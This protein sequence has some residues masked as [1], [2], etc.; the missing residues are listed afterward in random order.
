MRKASACRL[1]HL[2]V[3]L[4]ILMGQDILSPHRRLPPHA[5]LLIV[6]AR[7]VAQRAACCCAP[8]PLDAATLGAGLEAE[9][10]TP[11]AFYNVVAVSQRPSPGRISRVAKAMARSSGGIFLAAT[12]RVK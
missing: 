12:N 1:P 11:N 7:P 4:A 6:R 8:L 10:V 9:E 3:M 2:P 5:T